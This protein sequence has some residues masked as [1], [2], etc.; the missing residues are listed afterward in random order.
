MFVPYSLGYTAAKTIENRYIVN[1][2]SEKTG[3]PTIASL[4]FTGIKE[5]DTLFVLGTGSSVTRYSDAQWSTIADNDS[6]GVNYWATHDFVPDFY[7][8]ELPRNKDYRDALYHIFQARAPEYKGT[9]FLL[10][11]IPTLSGEIELSRLPQAIKSY[12][13]FSVETGIPRNSENLTSLARGYEIIDNLG[14]FSQK[15]IN[16]IPYNCASIIYLIL[17]GLRMGYQGIVLCGV[18]LSNP[19]H[20][21]TEKSRHYLDRGIPVKKPE[22]KRKQ[23]K[24]ANKSEK[25]I[26]VPEVISVLQQTVLR[27]YNCSLYIGAKESALYPQLPYYFDQPT[28]S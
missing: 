6:V 5:S 19:E 17:L 11:D 24:T 8:F 10:K 23:H 4:D 28:D 18:D 26:T 13:Y 25:E 7:T 21:Y 1:K 22:V 12:L 15:S 27:K 16:V 2:L 14:Y 20:F 3:V 9:P